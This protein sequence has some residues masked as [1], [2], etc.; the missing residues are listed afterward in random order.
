[1]TAVYQIVCLSKTACI[2]SPSSF[3]FS[4][5]FFCSDKSAICVLL[6]DCNLVITSLPKGTPRP[7]Q[8]TRVRGEEGENEL[9][10]ACG[11]LST[12]YIYIATY[13]TYFNILH[14]LIYYDNRNM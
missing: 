7:L 9:S 2:I 6:I 5:L 12:I 13:S 3:S 10:Y 11:H 8:C 14:A 1:M 4:F